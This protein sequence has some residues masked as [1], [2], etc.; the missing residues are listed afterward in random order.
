MKK[1]F[2][3]VLAIL[4][5]LSLTTCGESPVPAPEAT[6]P[7]AATVEEFEVVTPSGEGPVPAPEATKPAATVEEL[8]VVTPSAED[9]SL[10]GLE[11]KS[12][13][14]AYLDTVLPWEGD[15]ELI[16]YVG[17]IFGCGENT[18]TWGLYGFCTRSGKIVTKPVFI[19]VLKGNA[20]GDD[21]PEGTTELYLCVLGFGGYESALYYTPHGTLVRRGLARDESFEFLP[22]PANSVHYVIGGLLDDGF[23]YI[24]GYSILETNENFSV[25]DLP[26]LSLALGTRY[27]ICR[28]SDGVKVAESEVQ[29]NPTLLYSNLGNGDRLYYTILD[30]VCTTYDQNFNPILQVPAQGSQFLKAWHSHN[31]DPWP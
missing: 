16:P 3:F 29:P 7:A 15:E 12:D 5:L 25:A 11:T 30:G 27:S 18:A 4:A 26:L 10:E 28:K 6:E 2:A 14:L 17:G 8:E 24:D 21:W 9:L 22:E 23:Y 31:A 1:T 19:E 13:V 20:V